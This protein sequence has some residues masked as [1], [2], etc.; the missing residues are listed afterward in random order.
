MND[1]LPP[2]LLSGR[3][4]RY[5]DKPISDGITIDEDNN[6]YLGDLGANAIGVVT[7]DRKYRLIARSQDLSWVDSFCFGPQGRLYAVVNR[8][9]QSSVLNAGVALSR[10]AIDTRGG[11]AF[12]ATSRYWIQ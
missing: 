12:H 11:G 7:A 5:S 6:I 2:A 9:H 3:V 1:T 10:P 4:E 8:L